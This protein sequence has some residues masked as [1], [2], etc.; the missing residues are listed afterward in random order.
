MENRD[1]ELL[2]TIEEGREIYGSQ[3][4]D[5]ALLELYCKKRI[6]TEVVFEHATNASDM[7]LKLDGA[8][9]SEEESVKSDEPVDIFD[10]KDHE[11]E[12]L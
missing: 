3:S 4:F 9:S 12:E 6:S 11:E 10:L 2:D 7:K 8:C 5:Q 1:S